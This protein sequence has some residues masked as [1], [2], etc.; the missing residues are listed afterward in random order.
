MFWAQMKKYKNDLMYF[1]YFQ[2][3][4]IQIGKILFPK[5][6]TN[7]WEFWKIVEILKVYLTAIL[8]NN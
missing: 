8:Q 7:H 6:A 4:N 1:S 5:L 3:I 2:Y